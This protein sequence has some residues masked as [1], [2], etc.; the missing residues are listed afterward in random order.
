MN[1]LTPG[2]LDCVVLRPIVDFLSDCTF[3]VESASFTEGSKQL[4]ITAAVSSVSLLGTALDARSA[5]SSV[6][7]IVSFCCESKLSSEILSCLKKSGSFIS[8]N[9]VSVPSSKCSCK[10]KGHIET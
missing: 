4:E 6:G 1:E 5:F 2:R 10:R 3:E 7:I 8:S 9:V